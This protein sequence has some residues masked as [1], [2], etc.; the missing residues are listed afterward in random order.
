MIKFALILC[1]SSSIVVRDGAITLEDLGEIYITRQSRIMDFRVLRPAPTLPFI[2]MP[3]DECSIAKCRELAKTNDFSKRDCSEGRQQFFKD[4]FLTE[5]QDE[6]NYLLNDLLQEA[7]EIRHRRDLIAGAS[8]VASLANFGMK[9]VNNY[10]IRK[11]KKI[12]MHHQS[13]IK[14]L[15]SE[16]LA[17]QDVL[18]LSINQTYSKIED[19]ARQICSL[20]NDLAVIRARDLAFEQ[21][22]RYLNEI[23]SEISTLQYGRLPARAEYRN[24]F[25]GACLASCSEMSAE[26]CSQYCQRVL[27][28]TP[29]SMTPEFFGANITDGGVVINFR[30]TLP[31]I[32]LD[33]T[34]NYRVSSF[35]IVVQNEEQM[36]IQQAILEPFA[37]FLGE[38][39]HEIDRFQCLST[40][41]HMICQQSALLPYQCLNNVA[42]CKVEQK[43][44][45]DSCT[46]VY[47]SGGLIVYASGEAQHRFRT[48]EHDL[49]RRRQTFTGFKYFPSAPTDQEVICSEQIIPLRR[50]DLYISEEIVIKTV[51]TQ[52]FHLQSISSLNTTR[53]QMSFS[54]VL[55]KS[56]DLADELDETQFL[57]S[58][59]AGSVLLTALLLS[60]L[61]A[62]YL[63]YTK[64]NLKTNINMLKP[65][66]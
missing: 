37:T 40:R 60:C 11:L 43:E 53:I 55:Q 29:S 38:T 51:R 31:T 63:C 17:T 36:L 58:I 23:E 1:V 5:I 61:L 50:Q 33:P 3:F 64:K 27:H 34:P 39:Y 8:I 2:S 30:L 57:G 22:R 47:T 15:A 7:N 19:A 9:I 32:L 56:L 13:M 18:Q 46:F 35:G 10:Q 4:L 48:A 52:T 20:G 16:I 44:T 25:N 12:S 65:F 14:V 59:I 21:N 45:K 26:K 6:Y 62:L 24:I 54:S 42:A 66:L 28:E 41:R 49:T